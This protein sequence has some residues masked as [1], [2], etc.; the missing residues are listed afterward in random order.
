MYFV[1]W[2]VVS[3]LVSSSAALFVADDWSTGVVSLS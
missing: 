3:A 2:F 1:V